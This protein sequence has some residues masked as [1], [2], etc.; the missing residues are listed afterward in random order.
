[1]TPLKDDD[2]IKRMELAV[3]IEKK[4][5]CIDQHEEGQGF[6]RRQL[7]GNLIELGRLNERWGDWHG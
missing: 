3:E 2:Q 7:E 6:Y 5:Q 4:R 1:M